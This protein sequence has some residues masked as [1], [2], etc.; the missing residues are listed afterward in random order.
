[1]S[2]VASCG[3]LFGAADEIDAIAGKRESAQREMERRIVAQM[4]TCMDDLGGSRTCEEVEGGLAPGTPGRH[5]LVIGGLPAFRH[6]DLSCTGSN[7]I[8]F[9]LFI[10]LAAASLPIPNSTFLQAVSC[11]RGQDIYFSLQAAIWSR[12]A[13]LC[14]ETLRPL[15]HTLPVV[16]DMWNSQR[17]K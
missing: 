8:D 15:Q 7:E 5:V 17:L 14:G 11:A 3:S 2:S 12:Y 16:A 9:Q 6:G 4:L 1:M 13:W 10:P